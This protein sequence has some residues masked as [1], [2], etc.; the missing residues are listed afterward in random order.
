M[1]IANQ[2]I[3]NAAT[4]QLSTTL[5]GL[6]KANQAVSSGKRINTLSD[7]PVA[8]VQTLSLRSSLSNMDQLERNISTAKNWLDGGETALDSVKGL[9]TDAKTLAIQMAN[10]TM[11]DSERKDAA[12]QVEGMLEQVVSLANTTVNGQY[13][14]AGT[15]TDTKPFEIQ[16]DAGGNPTGVSYSGNADPFAVNVGKDI[17]EQVGH[18]GEAIFGDS[19]SGI[20]KTLID[21]KGYL[22]TNNVNGIEQSMGNLDS[23]L[24]Q[25]INT[26]SG[27]G[28]K[29]AGLD[30]KEKIMSDLKFSYTERKS[31]LEDADMIQAIS[32]LNSKQTAYQAALASSA[33]V[34]QMSLLNYL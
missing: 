31:S 13:I 21:L 18:D 24:N 5:E 33:K 26:V 4:L 8:L 9:I 23:D 17:N 20:F 34:T 27:I 16:V 11:G 32:D 2:S 30:I 10:G 15:K 29:G 3:F 22:E 12:A 7:D 14:F 6:Y 25:I 28:A 19:S 1:R